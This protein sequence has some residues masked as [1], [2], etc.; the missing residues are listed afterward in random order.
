MGP[1]AELLAARVSV[2]CEVKAVVAWAGEECRGKGVGF[3][4]VPGHGG[5]PQGT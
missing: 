5:V 2:V 1:G 4:L 3:W